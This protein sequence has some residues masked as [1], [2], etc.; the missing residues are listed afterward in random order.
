MQ[1]AHVLAMAGSVEHNSQRLVQTAAFQRAL[2]GGGGVVI[3]LPLEDGTWVQ[4]S[5]A[6]YDAMMKNG[7][8]LAQEM[9]KKRMLMAYLTV[10]FVCPEDRAL[11]WQ[12]YIETVFTP[13][14]KVGEAGVGGRGGQRRPC[15]VLDHPRGDLYSGRGMGGEG[16]GGG[17]GGGGG[18]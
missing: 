5:N 17:G 12:S 6:A 11:Y 16:G 1:Q 7:S 15:A 14:V 10:A 18:R 9:F 4:A 8:C 13:L 3:G 2:N